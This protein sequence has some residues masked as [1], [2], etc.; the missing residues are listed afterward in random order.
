MRLVAYCLIAVALGMVVTSLPAVVVYY[1]PSI[2][3]AR[4]LTSSTNQITAGPSQLNQ[5][6]LKSPTNQ[7]RSLG[8]LTTILVE[9]WT[10]NYTVATQGRQDGAVGQESTFI[11]LQPVYGAPQIVTGGLMFASVVFIISRYYVREKARFRQ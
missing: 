10:G 11:Q 9:L 2:A 6:T 7:T 5:T 3:H 8:N 1:S 4:T